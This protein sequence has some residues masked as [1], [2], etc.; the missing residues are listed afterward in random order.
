M[1]LPPPRTV[2]KRE[3]SEGMLLTGHVRVNVYEADFRLGQP[4]LPETGQPALVGTGRLV[5]RRPD[6]D[7]AKARIRLRDPVKLR[8]T[9][10][11]VRRQSHLLHRLVVLRRRRSGEVRPTAIAI[12]FSSR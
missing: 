12:R 10:L 11:P 9:L 2:E 4:H 1:T 5:L 6:V 8:P 3:P 7:D